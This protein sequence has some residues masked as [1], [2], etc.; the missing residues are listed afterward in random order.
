MISSFQSEYK[1]APV[2]CVCV[3]INSFV[4]LMPSDEQEGEDE[5][6]HE[7]ISNFRGHYI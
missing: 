4:L 7:I 2:V 6:F 3:C 5:F 1:I